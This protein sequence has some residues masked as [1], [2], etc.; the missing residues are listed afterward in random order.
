M[1]HAK[2]FL[3]GLLLLSAHRTAAEEL[4]R[5]IEIPGASAYDQARVLKILR[6]RPGQKLRA[7]AAYLAQVLEQRY[8]DDGYLG[9]R[10]IGEFAQ[11]EGL[12]TLRVDE[13]RLKTITLPGLGPAAEARARGELGL[14]P[15]RLLR[16]RDVE[17]AQSRLDHASEGALR[18]G[19]FEVHPLDD[20]M[21]LELNPEVHRF[22]TTY[23]IQGPHTGGFYNRVDGLN[24]GASLGLRV[25]DL[26]H[27][28]HTYVTV[29]G[30]YGLG[31]DTLRYALGLSRAVAA[32]RV[33]LGYEWHDLTDR[34]D[35]YRLTGLEEGPGT[36]LLEGSLS[37]F[38]RRRGHE[39][40]VFLRATPAAEFGVS[41]RADRYA[42]L[43][44]TTDGNPFGDGNARENPAIDPGDMRSLLVTARFTSAPTL[45]S[46]RSARRH[47]FLLRS[48]WGTREEVP[49][50]VR[51]EATLE[52]AGFGG[53]FQF[54]R[55]TS[56]LRHRRALG[57]F[58]RLDA[59]VLLGLGDD[60]S[61]RQ[62][63]LILGG[64]GTLRGYP[65]AAFG[66]ETLVVTTAELSARGP[67]ALPRLIGFYDGGATW[68]GAVADSG[69]KHSVGAGL[70]WPADSTTFVRVD[71]ARAIGDAREKRTRW[72]WRLQLPL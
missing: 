68:S 39:G 42:S 37:D 18:P 33:T 22:E 28:D 45:F 58:L 1:V 17:Q 26:S 14:E 72:L 62:R 48:L 50:G 2:A 60:K 46:E 69:W 30:A 31:S 9:V 71:A 65:L 43:P 34:D 61:P 55:L 25:S 44:T 11:D 63:R 15:G 24:L 23:G 27:Y 5:R 36:S 64:A 6:V 41:F 16:E 8:H 10:V 13:S 20:G 12:L 38:Y 7:P 52:R 49:D 59:R 47:S 21:Q 35:A 54:T 32:G 29:A 51:L 66:G 56:N 19:S 67:G 4:V 57:T 40:F 53:D 3:V 70:R